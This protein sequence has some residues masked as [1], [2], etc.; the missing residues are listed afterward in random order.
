MKYLFCFAFMLIP[1]ATLARSPKHSNLVFYAADNRQIEYTGRIDFSNL[2]KPRFWLPGV[3]LQA[4]FEGTSLEVD[5][6]DEENGDNR[7]YIEIAIDNNKPFRIKLGAKENKIDVANNLSP[8][9]HTVTICKDTESGIGYIEFL[10]LKC[11]KLLPFEKPK[12]KI[13]FI[14]DSITCGSGMDFSTSTCETGKWYDQHNAYLSYGPL[15]ARGLGAQWFLTAVSGIGLIH[16]CC[17]LGITMPQV[18]DKV[19]MRDDSPRWDFNK[20][21]PDVVTICLG[22]NDGK[23]DSVAFCAAYIGFIHKIR[24]HYPKADIICLNSPMAN[25]ELNQM[26]KNYITSVQLY[27]NNS[28]DNKVYHYFFPHTY[29]NGCG[30]HPGMA[31]HVLIAGQLAGYIKQLENW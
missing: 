24:I 27:L 8:G 12:R 30:G 22:Q 19:S 29:N 23:Q 9:V 3:Y 31:Q 15:A 25:P 10:G 28:G 11:E 20:Y 18:F 13:E 17:N 6:N 2:L 7:N 16:S 5:L 1:L 4:K 21:M 26:L 14:G